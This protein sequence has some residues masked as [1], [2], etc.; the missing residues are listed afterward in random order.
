MNGTTVSNNFQSNG[1]CS[2]TCSGYAFAVVQYKSCWC[3]N[4]VPADTASSS[5]CGV[6]CPGYP[7]ESCGDA[8][9]GFYGYVAL[10]PSPS[11]TK[12]SA[13]S[14]TSVPASSTSTTAAIVQSVSTPSS[15]PPASFHIQQMSIP[16]YFI[17]NFLGVFYLPALLR[18][19][20]LRGYRF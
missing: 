7:F 19:P 3:S 6:A 17:I 5:S 20:S 13:L 12:G 2:T 16:S 15:A 18:S 8:S 1:R 4:Y 10:G 14:S 11:G 9:S